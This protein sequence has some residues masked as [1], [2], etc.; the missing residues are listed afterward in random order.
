MIYMEPGSSSRPV[1]IDAEV[2]NFCLALPV[3]TF[4]SAEYEL[5]Q[6]WVAIPVGTMI[7]EPRI[8]SIVHARHR[9]ATVICNSLHSLPT[10][11]SRRHTRPRQYLCTDRGDKGMW[12]NPPG[13]RRNMVEEMVL[14]LVDEVRPSIMGFTR[15]IASVDLGVGAFGDSDALQLTRRS[16]CTGSSSLNEL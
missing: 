13:R 1:A 2:R 4:S 3:F 8:A 6:Y 11:W 5:H 15:G 7:H 14:V 10:H 12:P 9:N 16:R